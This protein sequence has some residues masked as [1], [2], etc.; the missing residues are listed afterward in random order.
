[1]FKIYREQHDQWRQLR[2]EQEDDLQQMISGTHHQL[3]NVEENL[4]TNEC[5]A[6]NQTQVSIS[7]F[8]GV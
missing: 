7:D 1:M 5:Q 6:I 3:G 2:R 4:V 8:L